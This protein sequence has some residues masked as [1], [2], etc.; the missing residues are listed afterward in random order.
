MIARA[1]GCCFKYGFFFFMSLFAPELM[2]L[3]IESCWSTKGGRPIVNF[4]IQNET[5]DDILID[6]GDLPWMIDAS[7]FYAYYSHDGTI[8]PVDRMYVIEDGIGSD[9]K[10]VPSGGRISGSIGLGYYFDIGKF[11][12]DDMVILWGYSLTTGGRRYDFSKAFFLH[13]KKDACAKNRR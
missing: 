12:I 1:I 11:P 9:A 10:K 3:S 4:Y 5:S 7:A 8:I 13:S 6:S 2:A